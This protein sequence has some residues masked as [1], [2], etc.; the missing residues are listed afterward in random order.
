MN[1]GDGGGVGGVLRRID[2]ALS[3]SSCF[4]SA[5]SS[6]PCANLLS[7]CPSQFEAWSACPWALAATPGLLFGIAIV[8][9]AI[10]TYILCLQN[11]NAASR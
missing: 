9:V 10:R 2:L 6:L 8:V 1:V 7:P 4:L 5:S 3:A 11:R